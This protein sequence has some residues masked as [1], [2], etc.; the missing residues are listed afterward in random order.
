[1]NRR[2][3]L[4]S[5]LALS[6]APAIVR[7]S[8]LMPV[9]ARVSDWAIL[10]HAIKTNTMQSLPGRV[11]HVDRTLEISNLSNVIIA[12]PAGAALE[13]SKG[14]A[15]AFALRGPLVDIE[16]SHWSIGETSNGAMVVCSHE[17]SG[18]YRPKLKVFG[19]EY[20]ARIEGRV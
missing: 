7:A 4:A 10:M 18:A 9:N 12:P 20:F 13:F 15:T 19:P 14:V 2:G 1:M 8:S 3:F 16:V 17:V 11:Y 5:M 6:A